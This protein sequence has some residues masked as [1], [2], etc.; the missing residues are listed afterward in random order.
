MVVGDDKWFKT[1]PRG[2][3]EKCPCSKKRMQPMSC[4]CEGVQ[5]VDVRLNESWEIVNSYGKV[6]SSHRSQTMSFDV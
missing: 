4:G 6:V 2:A 1:V 5:Y 3:E